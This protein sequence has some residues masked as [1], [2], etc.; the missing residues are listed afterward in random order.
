VGA[1]AETLNTIC[2]Q[3]NKIKCGFAALKRLKAGLGSTLL[4]AFFSY[5]LTGKIVISQ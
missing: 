5:I 4:L 2:S 3:C 1:E